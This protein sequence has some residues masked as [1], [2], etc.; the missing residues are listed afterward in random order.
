MRKS[1]AFLTSVV[2]IV[3]LSFS[4][5]Y[6]ASGLSASGSITYNAW[7]WPIRDNCK[8]KVTIAKS[9]DL[10]FFDYWMVSRV[11]DGSTV[12][13]ENYM[14][15]PLGYMTSSSNTRVYSRT[16]YGHGT[17]GYGI[18]WVKNDSGQIIACDYGYDY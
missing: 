18:W 3:V 11:Y 5:V 4:A 14:E 15:E 16:A 6:A 17:K 13:G 2:L 1:I 12:V 10:C 8:T 9:D 7:L